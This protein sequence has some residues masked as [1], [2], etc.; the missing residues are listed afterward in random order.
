MC[1][2]GEHDD[3][4][5]LRA[6]PAVQAAGPANGK[7]VRCPSDIL[8]AR[9][10]HA[11]GSL[12]ERAVMN[13]RAIWLATLTACGLL[14]VLLGGIILIPH[15]LYPPLSAADLRGIASAQV[16]IQLQQVQSQLANGARSVVLQGLAGLVLVVGAVATWWQVHISRE[17]QITDRFTK[18]VDQLGNPNVDVR[19]GGLYALERIAR[20]SAADRNAIL[21]LLGAFIRTHAPWPVGTPGG[22]EHPTPTVDEHLPWM[23]VRAADM[24]AAMGVLGRLPPSRDEQAIS[25]SRVDLR[26]I[27]LRDSRLSG[28]R[29]RYA[30]LARSALGGVWL[31]HSDLTA[32]DLRRA[33]LDHAHLAR[34]NLSRATLQG[35]N[36][37]R[38][39]LS[40]ADLRGTDL[41]D[42]ILDGT[43][44]TGAQ[45]DK[46]TIWP[47]GFDAEKRRQL[48]II[49]LC[50][51]RSITGKISHPS[52]LPTR[53]AR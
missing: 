21:F 47:V 6:E 14:L 48:G 15:L 49:E 11:S 45:A 42:T 53:R 27:A 38:A 5:R 23:R 31:E 1:I 39:D 3:K 22:P 8:A 19:I 36:L 37:H 24:Q 32:A 7:R 9:G 40:Y 10:E 18:A 30:N 52:S 28:S 4:R 43:M 13:Q 41:S 16:R 29:F 44:L 20:N 25:L 2:T 33:H 12:D 26:S 35:A 34:A 50:R 46:A 17:G 51:P